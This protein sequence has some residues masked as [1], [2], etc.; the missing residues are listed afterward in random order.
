MNQVVIETSKLQHNI[1]IIKELIQ[2]NKY[3]DGKKPIIIGILKGN[4]YG[5]GMILLA[6]KLLDNNI[7]FFAVSEIEE[8]KKLRQNGFNNKILVL[9][10]TGVESEIEDVIKFDLIATIGS[11]E[12]A[13]K[14]NEVAKSMRKNCTSTYKN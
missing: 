14:L 9:N 8:A 12:V 13:I 10:S 5:M 3:V 4:G 1:N 2:K 7:D 6:N 11:K